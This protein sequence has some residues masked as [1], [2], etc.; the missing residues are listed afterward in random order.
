MFDQDSGKSIQYICELTYCAYLELN[1]YVWALHKALEFYKP[2]YRKTCVTQ[3][4]LSGKILIF[5]LHVTNIEPLQK[6]F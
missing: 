6:V 1:A 2:S 4:D 5:I 3:V